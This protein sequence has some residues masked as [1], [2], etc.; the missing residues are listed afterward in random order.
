MKEHPE[1]GAPQEAPP[2]P[3]LSF[4]KRLRTALETLEVGKCITLRTKEDRQTVTN[5]VLAVKK[6]SGHL[7]TTHLVQSR[8]DEGKII[9]EIKRLPNGEG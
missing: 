5:V 4:S 9:I 2:P 8:D 3:K 7:L 6:K 1:I